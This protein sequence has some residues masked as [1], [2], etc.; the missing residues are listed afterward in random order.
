MLPSLSRPSTEA[1]TPPDGMLCFLAGVPITLIRWHTVSA[2][3]DQA[4]VYEIRELIGGVPRPRPRTQ[5]QSAP[6]RDNS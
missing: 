1:T 4:P 3:T 6:H 2:P 5:Q